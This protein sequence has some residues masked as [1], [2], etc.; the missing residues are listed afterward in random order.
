MPSIESP[1]VLVI[2]DESSV[3][4]A[5][6]HLLTQDGYKV[7]CID[8]PNKTLEVIKQLGPFDLVI[9]DILMPDCDGFD[10]IK[11]LRGEQPELRIMAISGGKFFGRKTFAERAIEAGANVALPKPFSYA[12][13][14][15]GLNKAMN[16]GA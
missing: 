10:L 8:L 7:T 5:I 2:D 6:S 1:R 13:L 15:S 11:E 16:E 4:R 9:T 14:M 3:L 12:E